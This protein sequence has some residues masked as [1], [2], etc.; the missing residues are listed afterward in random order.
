MTLAYMTD[1]QQ[2][3]RQTDSQ[4]VGSVLI[5]FSKEHVGQ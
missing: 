5:C 2:T 1:V 4:A 3:D